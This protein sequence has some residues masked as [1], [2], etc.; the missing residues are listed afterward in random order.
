MADHAAWGD[1]MLDLDRD[2]REPLVYIDWR[3]RGDFKCDHCE[4]VLKSLDG[5]KSHMKQAHNVSGDTLRRKLAADQ[6]ARAKSEKARQEEERRQA[7]ARK[8]RKV[9]LTTA[10]IDE[11]IT[12]LNS[13]IDKMEPYYA[14]GDCADPAR[15]LID[16]LKAKA[17]GRS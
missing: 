14:Q 7:E 10:E 15:D 11:I 1:D 5:L 12:E 2:D 9:V 16:R 13:L 3:Q 6:K 17:D 4:K 8:H